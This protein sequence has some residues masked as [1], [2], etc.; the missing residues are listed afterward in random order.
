MPLSVTCE[1]HTRRSKVEGSRHPKENIV[2]E[3]TKRRIFIIYSANAGL[4]DA[5]LK[6]CK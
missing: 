6:M 1:L 3:L 2:E 4:H 5:K